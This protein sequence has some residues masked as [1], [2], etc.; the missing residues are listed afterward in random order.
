MS[1]A[2]NLLKRLLNELDDISESVVDGTEKDNPFGICESYHVAG[3]L[4]RPLILEIR[5]FLGDE[6]TEDERQYLNLRLGI[7]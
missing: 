5:D 6:L 2:T 4:S 7:K 1:D 3:N